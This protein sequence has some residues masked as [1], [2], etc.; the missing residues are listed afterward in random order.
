MIS[1]LLSL[2]APKPIAATY[3][4][5]ILTKDGHLK[6][7]L[8]DLCREI[9]LE[10]SEVEVRPLESFKEKDINYNI[11]VLRYNHYENKRQG[12]LPQLT[13][14]VIDLY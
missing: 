4:P 10:P 3:D 5:I 6:E 1:N 9:G 7:Q 8:H 12:N 11:Q 13:P 2:Q 14:F